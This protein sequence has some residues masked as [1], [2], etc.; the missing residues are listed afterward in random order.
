MP[1]LQTTNGPTE[2]LFLY[3]TDLHFSKESSRYRI[4]DFV[5]DLLLKLNEVGKLVKRHKVPMVIIGGDLTEGPM[6]SLEMGDRVL[7]EIEGW[8]VPVFVVVGNHDVFGNQ[9]KT[10]DSAWL[11]HVFRRSKIIQQLDKLYVND[12]CIW[13]VHFNAGI[14]EELADL[15]HGTDSAQPLY[16]NEELFDAKGEPT[17][18]FDRARIAEKLVEITHAM[19]VPGGIHPNARQID[20]DEYKTR[21]DLILSGDYHPG[22]EEVYERAD[23]ARFVNPGAFARRT[24]SDSDCKRQVRVVLVKNDTSTEFLPIECMKPVEEVFDLEAAALS[25]K[26]EK[27][28]DTFMQ[29]LTSTKTERVDVRE[30]I[31]ELAKEQKVPSKIVDMAL[32][33]YDRKVG[34]LQ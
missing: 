31:I 33:R 29:A 4:G 14:E 26:K 21:A 32:E 24:V 23:M 15:K 3:L 8:G 18:E 11:G 6:V 17:G 1:A 5:G 25:K 13:G 7:D 28:L 34:E 20:P 30:R 12:V 27:E 16:R 10:L 22:W 19:V 9:L 2:S